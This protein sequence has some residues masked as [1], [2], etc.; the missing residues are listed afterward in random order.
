[1]GLVALSPVAGGFYALSHG[2]AKAALFLVARRFPGRALQGW[3]ERPLPAGVWWPLCI[4]SLSI[5]GLPPL[6]GFTAKAGLSAGLS[7]PLEVAVTLLSMGTAAAYARFWGAP[8]IHKPAG[9]HT[10]SADSPEPPWSL[11]VILLVLALVVHGAAAL[12]W[13]EKPA[14]AVAK[15]AMVLLG[16]WGLHQLLEGEGLR[17]R[18]R[19]PELE[20][21]SDLLGGIG[22]VGAGLLVILNR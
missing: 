1:M 21:L 18:L 6:A 7:L 20:G 19:L 15:T 16:G 13:T 3:R 14:A 4:G 2:T 17:Q 22:V 5:V 9:G 11:G 10:A 8:L 12:P